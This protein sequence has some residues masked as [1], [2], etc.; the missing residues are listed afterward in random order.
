M[1]RISSKYSIHRLTTAHLIIRTSKI[2]PRNQMGQV[3]YPAIKINIKIHT[4]F[5]IPHM[6]IRREKTDNLRAKIS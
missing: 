4:G 6:P 3:K 1:K 2:N 5:Q